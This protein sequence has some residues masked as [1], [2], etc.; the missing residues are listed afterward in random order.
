MSK[1]KTKEEFIEQSIAIYGEKYNYSQI[2]YINNNTKVKIICPI[3]GD[4]YVRPND[5][6]SKKVGCNKCSNASITKSKNVEKTIIERF[7][8]VHNNKYDYSLM[9]YS[10][11]D[12]KIKIICPIHDKFLQSPHH[13]LSGAGCQKCGNVYKKTTQDF[14]NESKKIHGDKYDY[15]MVDYKNNRTKINIICSKHGVFQVRPNDHLSKKSGCKKCIGYSEEEFI[16]YAN[17]IHKNRYDYS[18]IKIQNVKIK[19][20]IICPVH[21]IFYQTIHNH[22]YGCGCPICK[23]SKGELQIKTYLDENKIKYI[24]EK[25][26]KGCKDKR[27]LPFDFY[28]PKQ[29]ICIEFDGEQH[30][31][32]INYFGG[33]T[34]FEHIKNRDKI[35]NDFCIKNNI[36]L[37]RLT[38][39]NFHE[40]EKL[41]V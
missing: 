10:G 13:H 2:E 19:I 38:K 40:I 20:E 15:S 35:K 16:N 36:K 30:F 34:N 27:M 31:K 14:I 7:N 32:P 29:N 6:F 23:L 8:K 24:R 18:S 1:R 21:G 9:D 4:F 28:L 41:L 37:I 5:H 12:N 26:F 25:K 17:K 3:H 11:T 33:I 22:L 39:E